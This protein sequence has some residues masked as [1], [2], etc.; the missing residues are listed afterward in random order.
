V[1]KESGEQA[2]TLTRALALARLGWHVFPVRMPDK[3]PLVKWHG[4]ATTEAEV[5]AGWWGID[6]PDAAIGIHTGKSD[7]VVVDIDEKG[8]DTPG[9]NGHPADCGGSG[10]QALKAADIKSPKTFAYR[11]LSGGQH[12]LYRAPAGRALT[13]AQN[14]PVLHVDIRAGNGFAVYYGPDLSAL[15]T[16]ADAPEWALLDAKAATENRSA[17]ADAD[18]FRER[19]IPGKPAKPVRQ[20]LKKVTPKGMSH[21]D[22]L[23]AVTELVKLGAQGHRGVADALEAA[24]ETYSSGW[25]EA[26]RHWDNALDGSV[27]RIGLPPA[28]FAIP[29]SERKAIAARNRPE[30][31][32]QAKTEK[33]AAVRIAHHDTAVT[34]PAPGDR[35][36]EDGPLAVELAAEL[37]GT[38]AY[39]DG[40]GLMRYDGRR[41][42]KAQEHA[43]TEAVRARLAD[44]EIEEHRLAVM[45]GATAAELGKVSSLLSRARAYAVQRLVLGIIAETEPA[46]DAYPHLLNTP[47]GIVDLRTRELLPHDPAFYLTKMTGVGFDPDADMT[48]W[49]KALEALPEKVRGWVQVRLGQAVTGFTPDDDM[50]VIFEGAGENG[51]TTVLHAPRKA[52]GDYAVTVPERLLIANPNDHPTTLMT[53]MGARLAVIE[54][55]PEGRSLNVKRLKDTVGTPEIT[56]RRM[57][58]HLAPARSGPLPVPLPRHRQGA[59]REARPPRRPHPQAATR[60]AGRRRAALARG[61]RRRVVC[62]R[63]G[64]AAHAGPRRARHGGLAARRRPDPRLLHRA[65]RARR[66]HRH[67]HRG[68]RGRLQRLARAPR[69]PPLVATD[70]QFALRR[71]RQHGGRHPQA[72]EVLGH[73]APLAARLL[74]AQAHPARHHLVARRPL[75]RRRGARPQRGRT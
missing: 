49:S 51:K 72:G 42:R 17:S 64:D 36:L 44:I 73:R 65:P 34:A 20:A 71:A 66:A 43:L 13:I 4:E 33:K 48:R 8:C 18:A 56:A 28:T 16:L 11:T 24:R 22:M 38:W 1:S 12:R 52:L 10:S 75:P 69:A 7:L 47:T 62:Q 70:D 23:E 74:H 46:F 61:G 55:L 2:D 21:G 41:W 32:E 25:P 50:L 58:R 59:D 29:K 39:A 68:S 5:I 40:L 9:R 19:L 14:V 27:K 15:P 3:R 6:F 30:V 57:P 31:V 63:R 37:V 60:R 54:E 35:I 53:L 67:P 45:R 26:G